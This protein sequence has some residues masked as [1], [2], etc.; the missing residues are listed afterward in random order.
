MNAVLA[1]GSLLKNNSSILR[2]LLN[3][4]QDVDPVATLGRASNFD[5]DSID[6]EISAIEKIMKESPTKYFSDKGMT[7]KYEELV[8]TREKLKS[9]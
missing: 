4:A 3:L 8:T 9:R 1:D 6:S 5:A 7:K 2:Q